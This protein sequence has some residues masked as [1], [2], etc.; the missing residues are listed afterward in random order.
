M[1][2]LN[3]AGRFDAK[4][5]PAPTY[6]SEASTGTMFVALPVEVT[7]GD[8]AGEQITAFLPIS[9]NAIEN[10]V[11]SLADAFG[12]AGNFEDLYR[13]QCPFVGAACSITTAIEEYQGENKCKVKWVNK[14]GGGNGIKPAEEDKFKTMMARFGRKAQALGEARLKETGQKPVT[15][16]AAKPAAAATPS[17]NKE[18]DL[19]F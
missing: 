15:A 11:N 13:G 2:T 8:H 17:A 12:Y 4:V 16:A 18:D 7:A 9:D 10:T 6:I 3:V 14:A 1:S 5:L 19:P